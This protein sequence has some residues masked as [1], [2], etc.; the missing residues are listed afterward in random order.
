VEGPSRERKVQKENYT[1]VS[2]RGHRKLPEPSHRGSW[3]W[4]DGRFGEADLAKAQWS[5]NH[6][7]PKKHPQIKV[8]M[9]VE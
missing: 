7:D 2:K 4:G 9:M 6:R 3:A 1:E 8:G 5:P